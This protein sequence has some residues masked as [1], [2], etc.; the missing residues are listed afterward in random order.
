MST[1]KQL[2]DANP[3]AAAIIRNYVNTKAAQLQQTQQQPA[4]QVQQQSQGTQPVQIAQQPQQPVQ[5]SKH[6][7]FGVDMRL[8]NAD[9]AKGLMK[10][11][12]MLKEENETRNALKAS[13]PDGSDNATTKPEKSAEPV[14]HIDNPFDDDESIKYSPEY[15]NGD[16]T[17]KERHDNVKLTNPEPFNPEKP[18]LTDMS[19]PTGVGKTV[20]KQDKD[21]SDVSESRFVGKHGRIYESIQDPALKATI[22]QEYINDD[23]TPDTFSISELHDWIDRNY[24]EVASD[25]TFFD[26]IARDIEQHIIYED[27]I[28]DNSI[29]S[30]ADGSDDFEDFDDV[31]E[32]DIDVSDEVD[33]YITDSGL[34]DYDEEDATDWYIEKHPDYEDDD[35]EDFLDLVSDEYADDMNES[36]NTMNESR[37]DDFLESDRFLD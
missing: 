16:I 27:D 31:D 24:P 21:G 2:I 26:S 20:F 3:Q 25:P 33:E 23:K 15:N 9:A 32:D 19:N 30:D 6:G 17:I 1:I 13:M 28:D 36:F 22:I 5:E 4:Q 7:L 12:T 18:K 10:Y 14:S 35:L 11:Q 37:D 34:F 29:F 8:V